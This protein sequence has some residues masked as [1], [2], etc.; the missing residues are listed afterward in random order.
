M[1]DNGMHGPYE[2]QSCPCEAVRELKKI[3][4]RHEHELAVGSTSFALIKQDLDHIKAAVE[5]KDRL[6]TNLLSSIVNIILS[7]LLGW[8]AIRLGMPTQ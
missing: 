8:L 4:E 6:G 7:L 2:K 5:K 3:V 1:A